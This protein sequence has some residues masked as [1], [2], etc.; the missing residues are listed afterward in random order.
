M[1]MKSTNTRKLLIHQKNPVSFSYSRNQFT[2]SQLALSS[3]KHDSLQESIVSPNHWS[4]LHFVKNNTYQYT[5]QQGFTFLN[6]KV[7][8]RAYFQYEPLYYFLLDKLKLNRFDLRRGNSNC[9]VTSIEQ[10]MKYV[11]SSFHPDFE[12][13][14]D[15]YQVLIK[16]SKNPLYFSLQ[17]CLF[18][19]NGNVKSL[20]DIVYRTGKRKI[21]GLSSSHELKTFEI[22]SVKNLNS[23]DEPLD[24][25]E[26]PFYQIG[27]TVDENSDNLPVMCD[28]ILVSL[29]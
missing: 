20:L 28:H 5:D 3:S 17:T 25:L 12:S 21:L 22:Q 26:T 14:D 6:S 18:D 10:D 1:R 15:Y 24:L 13:D 27:V 2:Q 19:D 4:S 7:F 8:E 29:D 16:G 9:L 11:C 23:E